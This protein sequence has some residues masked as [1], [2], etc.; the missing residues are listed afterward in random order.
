[1]REF[2]GNTLIGL[3]KNINIKMYISIILSVVLYECKTWSLTLK[4]ERWL[5]VFVNRVRRRDEVTGE[6]RKLHSEKRNDLYSPN[7]I[8]VSIQEECDGRGM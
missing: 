4:E 6:W 5:R 2:T 7:I 8:R 3:S 1:L